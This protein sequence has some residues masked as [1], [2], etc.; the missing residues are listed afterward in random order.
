MPK[1]NE[2]LTKSDVDKQIKVFMSSEEFKR[3]VEK[4]VQARL[5]ATNNKE[6]EDK[7]VE[8]TRNVITQLFKTLWVKHG[9]WTSS[10]TNKPS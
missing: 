10:L 3:K 2:D 4:I 5:A 9:V 6:L 8:V 7:I 1:L